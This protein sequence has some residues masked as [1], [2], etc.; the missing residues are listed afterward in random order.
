M[1][2]GSNNGNIATYCNL[3]RISSKPRP[4]MQNEILDKNKKIDC[5]N[6]SSSKDKLMGTREHESI[7]KYIFLC[8]RFREIFC[9]FYPFYKERQMI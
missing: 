3:L 4:T 1:A 2:N 6:S 9:S 8:Y 7:P 5:C